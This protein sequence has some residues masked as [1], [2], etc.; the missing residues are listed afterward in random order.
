MFSRES[1]ILMKDEIIK[2]IDTLAQNLEKQTSTAIKIK[3]CRN[4]TLSN[5]QIDGF[6][7]GIDFQ[8]TDGINI[9]NT[10]IKEGDNSKLIKLLN[11]LKS[12][13]QNN[14]EDKGS[15]SAK[16]ANLKNLFGYIVPIAKLGTVVTEACLK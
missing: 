4:V 10:Q 16:L 15:I 8:T 1:I 6:D 5:V 12:E 11:D 2:G 9:I 14:P 7:I 13:L 3:D